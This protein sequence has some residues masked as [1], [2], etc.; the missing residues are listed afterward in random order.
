MQIQTITFDFPI[1]AN[2]FPGYKLTKPY[3]ASIAYE[4]NEQTDKHSLLRISFGGDTLEYFR[5]NSHFLADVEEAILS[6]I[7]SLLN[8]E[9]EIRAISDEVWQN[10]KES[11]NY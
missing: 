4:Y 11:I 6:N 1:P 7:E 8:R 9:T 3:H 2:Y 5:N 10:Y